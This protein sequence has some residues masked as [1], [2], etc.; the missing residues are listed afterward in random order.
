MEK[1]S[2]G[3][4]RRVYD[5]E[6]RADVLKMVFSGRSVAEVAESLGIRE[7]L[8][9]QWKK[10]YKEI[11]VQPGQVSGNTVTGPVSDEEYERIKARLRKP[12]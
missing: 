1:K 3:T 9:H 7:N 5:A 11:W 10:R 8:I 12:R 6:F 4:I 2:T